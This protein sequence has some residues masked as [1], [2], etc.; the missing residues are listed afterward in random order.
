[1]W[2]PR[3]IR[4]ELPLRLGLGLM[5]LYSGYSL[6]TNPEAW[7]S[8]V[9]VLPLTLLKIIDAVGIE[10]FLMGQGIFEV[11][12]AAVFLLWFIS[13]RWVKIAAF[14]AIVEMALILWL[15]GVDSITFRDMGLLGGL[16][17]LWLIYANRI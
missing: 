12:L 4:P 17:T 8:F 9:K 7:I 15:V 14:L 16:I 3:Q 2:S 13:I 6:I 10:R 11:A 1:M 5:Y